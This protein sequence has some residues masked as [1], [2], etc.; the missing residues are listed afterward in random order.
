MAVDQPG[1]E[2]GVDALGR[3]WW[4]SPGGIRS[5]YTESSRYFR[6]DQ[7]TYN[8]NSA[9]VSGN[10]WLWYDTQRNTV[11]QL[12]RD[13]ARTRVTMNRLKPASRHIIA[14]IMSRS[15]A[16]EVPPTDS[17]DATT[18]GALTAKSVVSGLAPRAQLGRPQGADRL[19]PVAGRHGRAVRRVGRRQGH[20]TGH[21]RVRYGLRHRR[22]VR[23]PAVD[24]GDVLGARRPRRREGVLVDQGAGPGPR[25]GE[26]SLRTET[27]CRR[28]TPPASAR[29]LR[30]T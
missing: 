30:S 8:V 22:P 5:K 1:F 15:L 27:T 3:Q 11:Q 19:E 21:D 25:R 23:V 29:L 24:S 16:F 10:Q 6:S 28:V 4:D 18:R 12:P 17:D 2:S 20:A 14:R 26:A 7:Y 9:F 13:P